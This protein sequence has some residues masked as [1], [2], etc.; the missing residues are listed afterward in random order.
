MSLAKK[1]KPGSCKGRKMSDE[2]KKL[3]SIAK[4][5]KPQSNEQIEKRRQ[6]IID[7]K[8]NCKKVIDASTGV[9]YDSVKQAAEV[10]GFK[11]GWLSQRLRGRNIN[12]TNLIFLKD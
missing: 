5:N 10:F 3:M 9:I 7:N 6:W 8:L 12:K 2:S 1:G 4:K 11:Y